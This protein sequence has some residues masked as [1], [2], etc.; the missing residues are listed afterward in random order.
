M[1]YLIRYSLVQKIMAPKDK[2]N[3]YIMHGLVQ[4]RAGHEGDS[5][6]IWDDYVSF[7]TAACLMEPTRKH[8]VRFRQQLV[9]HF[10]KNKQLLAEEDPVVANEGVETS[11]KDWRDGISMRR[12]VIAGVLGRHG[13]WRDAEE[14]L[15][16]VLRC[17]SR[18]LGPWQFLTHMQQ[19]IWIAAS[20]VYHARALKSLG[21]L[22]EAEQALRQAAERCTTGLGRDHQVTL[23]SIYWLADLLLGQSQYEEAE[24]LSRSALTEYKT[25][26]EDQYFNALK[27]LGVLAS[28]LIGQ[29]RYS[30]A[31]QSCRQVL[32]SWEAAKP[33]KH[34][35]V[36]DSVKRLAYVLRKQ[37]KYSDALL[38]YQRA[39][40]GYSATLGP[41]HADTIECEASTLWLQRNI[42]GEGEGDELFSDGEDDEFFSGED[43]PL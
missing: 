27:C 21:Q 43:E 32:K 15:R 3:G 17:L 33:E 18:T 35:G 37:E 24:R 40:Y 11:P 42:A 28:S 13:R 5:K 6:T 4:W 41:A 10:P 14:I 8:S 25:S 7:I 29:K 34:I 22:Q 19:H 26:Q 2:Q 30:E 36:L 39:W 20:M 1:R 23:W 31:E 9:L 12:A 38:Y 16:E